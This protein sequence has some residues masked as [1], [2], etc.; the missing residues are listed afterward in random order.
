MSVAERTLGMMDD[1]GY[2]LTQAQGGNY[3]EALRLLA[4]AKAADPRNIFLIA[5][6]KQVSRLRSG[7]MLPREK[8][9]VMQS[10]PGLVERAR[11]D[12]ERRGVKPAPAPQAEPRD[13]KHEKFRLVVDQY[14][15]HADE[16]LAKGDLES[17]MKEIERVLLIEPSNLKAKKYREEIDRALQ[18]LPA[19]EPEA[20]SPPGVQESVPALAVREFGDELVVPSAAPVLAEPA[21][22]P[23]RKRSVLTMV[24]VGVI[25]L[26][27]I[28]V[29][30]ITLV[31]PDRTKPVPAEASLPA[32]ESQPLA[33][34]PAGAVQQEA[35]SADRVEETPEVVPPP[36]T[37]ER[38]RSQPSPARAES[39]E[40]PITPSRPALQ[41]AEPA[42]LATTKPAVST[43]TTAGFIPVQRDPKILNLAT[44][45]FPEADL[46]GDLSG[47]VVVKVQIDKNGKPIQAQI[48][49]STNNTLNKPVVDAVMRS[50]F[51]PAM[52]SSGPVVSWMTIPIRLR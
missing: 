45:V 26:A 16:W 44:P 11:A 29:G 12:S 4:R 32:P 23:E 51:E 7:G 50:S 36:A 48:V 43:A 3:A 46:Y 42:A 28:A 39:A 19:E 5:L 49:S 31:L 47:Q 22:A 24:L 9:E 52:M 18:S 30:V 37:T 2:V 1:F 20:P 8:M 14:F 17:A 6:E 34:A 35:E 25:A 33:A 27:A 13:E 38:R 41:Q 15:Q 40:I 10:L 21:A